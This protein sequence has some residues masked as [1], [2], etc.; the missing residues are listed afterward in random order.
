M[1]QKSSKELLEE[2]IARRQESA[3][4]DKLRAKKLI[5]ES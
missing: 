4:P 2:Q 3:G 1:A 5:A